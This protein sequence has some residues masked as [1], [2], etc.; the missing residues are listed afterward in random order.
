[1]IFRSRSCSSCMANAS[2]YRLKF[3]T[4]DF[5]TNHWVG[6]P[7]L[8]WWLAIDLFTGQKVTANI[9]IWIDSLMKVMRICLSFPIKKWMSS[10]GLLKL[11]IWAKHRT[12]SRLQDKFRLLF[13]WYNLNLKMAALNLG[14]L[15][16]VL[17]LCL[18]FP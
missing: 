6:S 7:F 18:S 14:L 16:N 2:F 11:E 5:M 4:I 3:R 13:C 15:M 17:G 8:T 10:F 1:L 12:M 9:R